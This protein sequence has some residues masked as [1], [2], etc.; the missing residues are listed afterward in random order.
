MNTIRIYIGLLLLFAFAS[1]YK[2]KGD[3]DYH[4]INEVT[5][6]GIEEQYALNRWDTLVISS[7]KIENSLTENADLK[8]N[9]YLN[10]K[11]IGDTKDL[12]YVL[13]EKAG[14]YHGRLE[15][16]EPAA[17]GV[18]FF[19]DFKVVV[20]TQYAQGLMLLS[21][22]NGVPELSFMSTLDNPDNKI[23]HDIFKKE[24]KKSLSGTPLKIEQPD[25]WSGYAGTIWVHTSVASH[26]LDPIL[27]KEID[28]LDK[29]SFTEPV[30]ECDMVYCSYCVTA[31]KPGGFGGAIGRD[32]KI[33]P[34][35]SRQNRYYSAS[36]KPVHD[37]YKL[38]TTYDYSLSPML[39]C[40]RNAA[41]GYDNLT[42]RFLWFTNSYDIPSFD[43][44]QY[45]V[46]RVSKTHVGL[47]WLGWG[48]NMN[49]GNFCYTSLFFDAKTG[50]AALARQH[51][52]YGTMRGQDSL[53]ILSQ[54][55]LHDGSKMAVNSASNRLY[56]SDGANKVYMINLSDP[57]FVFA[58]S[59]FGCVLPEDCRITM[60]KM[61]SN[62][63]SLYVGVQTNRQEGYSGDV[64]KVSTRDGS[65]EEHYKGFG[66]A[67]IDIIEKV[68]VAEFDTEE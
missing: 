11:K 47:P 36:L 67:P 1:C 26:Q 18:R 45:D 68:E 39:L 52:S 8:Y 25:I 35:E 28:Y 32:G 63:T 13:S 60:L 49:A 29:N 56:Y 27:L 3:Y 64:Y 62:N 21:D 66:G 57:K 15:V 19:C 2:D 65:I 54:H 34:K 12:N 33:Y 55:Y 37:M 30:D 7:A 16:V 5:I 41:L 20:R 44:S 53:V 14:V 48:V 6:S 59:D 10:Y 38:D 51:N 58:S 61:A 9:W 17:D 24:N 50:E 40:S 22:N 31:P 46:V 43:E 42:G 23:A 4:A